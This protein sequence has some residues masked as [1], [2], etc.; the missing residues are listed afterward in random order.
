MTQE[1]GVKSAGGIIIPGSQSIM[2]SAAIVRLGLSGAVL[3]ACQ[4]HPSVPGSWA[5]VTLWQKN[6][7][8]I[9]IIINRMYQYLFLSSDLNLS[10]KV[11]V[12]S[13]LASKS[14]KALP[15]LAWYLVL[16][17]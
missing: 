9:G 5:E 14:A 15:A 16:A 10:C 1:S 7:F 11:H 6:H 8:D 17:P 3:A 2:Q 13:I 12:K 4:C